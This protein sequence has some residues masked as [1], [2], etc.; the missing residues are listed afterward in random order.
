MTPMRKGTAKGSLQLFGFVAG[1]T[2]LF[3]YWQG[4]GLRETLVAAFILSAFIAGIAWVGARMD[5]QLNR[6]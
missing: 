5:Q 4:Y 2:S 3:G 1:G 6:K